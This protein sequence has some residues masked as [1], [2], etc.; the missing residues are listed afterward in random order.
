MR[1]TLVLLAVLAASSSNAQARAPAQLTAL[2]VKVGEV[3]DGEPAVKVTLPKLVLRGLKGQVFSLGA[4]FRSDQGEWTPWVVTPAWT[5]PA[6]PFTWK[7]AFTHF[8]RMS[9]LADEDFA[10]GAFIVRVAAFDAQ[11]RELGFKEARFQLKAS[12]QARAFRVEGDLD[13]TH[14]T[15]EAPTRDAVRDQCRAWKEADIRLQG[16]V[17]RV[18]ITGG[19]TYGDVMWNTQRACEAVTAAANPVY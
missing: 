9:A 10:N 4:T 15:F 7:N 12:T 2:Q 18:G 13:W 17:S 16:F 19:P 14:F 1:R 5:V 11:G 3:Y 8:L 6:D